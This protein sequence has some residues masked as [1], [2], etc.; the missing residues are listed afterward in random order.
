VAVMAVVA[1]GTLGYVNMSSMAEN[2]NSMY[3]D[4]LQPVQW[5]NMVRANQQ[6]NEAAIME[7]LLM[8]DAQAYSA[9]RAR[10]QKYTEENDKLIEQYRTTN[11]D[12]YEVEHLEMYLESRKKYREVRIRFMELGEAGKKEEAM[13]VFN[14][15]LKMLRDELFSNLTDL[16]EHNAD[17]ARQLNEETLQSN[18]SAT[19]QSLWI[20]GVAAAALLGIGFGIARMI[21]TP[22]R[23]MQ[24]LMAQAEQGDLTVQG[25]YQSKDEI[26]QLSHS[27]NRMMQGLRQ[28][29]GG[30]R[31]TAV[32]LSASAEELSASGEETRASTEQ[33]SVTIQEVAHSA[34]L[35]MN[36]AEDGSRA[37]D[38][39]TLGVQRIAENSASVSDSSLQAAKEAEQG[40]VTLTG[41]L[42]QMRSIDESVQESVQII[43]R[44]HNGSQ[45]IAQIIGVITGIAKQTHMLA[46]NAA[47]EASRA[48]EQGRGFAVV[49]EEVRKLAEASSEAAQQV[50]ERIKVIQDDTNHSVHA[51]VRVTE[52][53][54]SGMEKMNEVGERF[55]RIADTTGKVAAQIED[56][57][58]TSQQMAAGS[59][60]IAAT[61]QEMVRFAKES[62]VRAEE[63]AA[64]SEEQTAAMA[65]I[66]DSAN[67]LSE[68]AQELQDLVIKF[69]A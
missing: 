46:L 54:G 14:M 2:S 21:S 64:S 37:I 49:A 41:A 68:L 61:V 44:L 59:Q 58:A 56:M 28:L 22:L 4:R 63:V 16:S 11:L 53:V 31:E 65:E 30:V 26:G 50:I 32:S 57:S 9:A 19:S 60:Q 17:V 10:I 34:D 66:S 1:V 62:A 20:T 35:Q 23:E 52:E 3:S 36:Q 6:G 12:A 15:E 48:G 13:Q 40:R 18:D 7:A 67:L 33:I 47:I 25:A 43:E 42:K 51:M 38:E 5:L 55:E 8:N 24:G 69:K 27:F 45:D 29:V 39:M